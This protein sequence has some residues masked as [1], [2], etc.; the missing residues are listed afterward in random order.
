MTTARSSVSTVASALGPAVY[1]FGV[2]PLLYLLIAAICLI[3][4]LRAMRR[5]LAPIGQLV[6]AVAAAA[7]VA[8][9]LGAAL[10]LLTAAV[11]SGH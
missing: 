5:A 8:L 6:Q 9:A 11:L 2:L 3:L 10:V 1:Q 7:L 4:A